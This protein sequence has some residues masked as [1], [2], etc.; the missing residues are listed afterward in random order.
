[1]YEN[2]N[3]SATEW[4]KLAV[5]RQFFLKCIK[6]YLN[7]WKPLAQMELNSVT[8]KLIETILYIVYQIITQ[9]YIYIYIYTSNVSH[10][11]PVFI[12][13]FTVTRFGFNW[14]P[15][16]GLLWTLTQETLY[17]E[18]KKVEVEVPSYISLIM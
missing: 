10:L 13:L 14:K 5:S 1:M 18:L 17:T 9:V 4:D 2:Q 6:N 7:N 15:P 11:A 12:N 3:T 16:P 8:M